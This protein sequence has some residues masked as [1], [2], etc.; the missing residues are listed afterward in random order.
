M[1]PGWE[2]VGSAAHGWGTPHSGTQAAIWNGNPLFGTGWGFGVDAVSEY[3]VRSVGAYFTTAPGVV[4]EMCGFE[5]GNLITVRIGDTD[6]SWTNRYA[7][8]NS[9][10]GR[11]AFVYIVGISSPDARYHFAMDD[12]TVVPV[13]EPSSLAA[14]LAGVAGFGAVLRRRTR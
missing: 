10:T 4:L 6:G 3:T 8:I 11:I 13:P 2:V 5:A 1:V 9:P 14:L 7:E 12:L